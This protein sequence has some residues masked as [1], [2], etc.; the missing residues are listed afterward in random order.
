VT[1]DPWPERAGVNLR[2]TAA[3]RVKIVIP[4]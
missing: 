1:M 4:S 3:R 2:K